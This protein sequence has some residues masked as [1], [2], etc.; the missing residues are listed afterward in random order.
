MEDAMAKLFNKLPGFT[1]APPGD[2]R[3][4]LR[5]LPKVLVFGSLLLTLP[6]LLVR[7]L[8]TLAPE[9][10][11]ATL[12]STVDIYSI[13]LVVLHWT[14]VLTVGI[15]AFIIMVMKGPAYVADPYP[16]IETDEP[17]LPPPG[18]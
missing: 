3:R 17:D 2:E 9:L 10:E 16:L 4:V 13:S 18:Q 5:L 12:V 6:A 11:S 7:L 1:Q 8:I 15:A 14:V